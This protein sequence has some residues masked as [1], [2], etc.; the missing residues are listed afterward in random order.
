MFATRILPR[1]FIPPSSSL[2]RNQLVFLTATAPTVR[3]VGAQSASTSLTSHF[4]MTTRRS[5]RISA[6]TEA[7]PPAVGNAP[8]TQPPPAPATRP[9]KRKASLAW[10]TAPPT[11]PK[12]RAQ[13][14]TT[15]SLPLPSTPTATPSAVRLIAEPAATPKGSQTPTTP[16]P[17]SRA[18][19]RL[20]D[21]N[22]T[23]APLLSPET[24]RVVS[25]S[26][27]GDIPTQH[28]TTTANILEDACAH[29]IKGKRC[30]LTSI[31]CRPFC[32]GRQRY[33]PLRLRLIHHSPLIHSH[34]PWERLLC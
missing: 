1:I 16:K 11:T 8:P 25:K 13:N 28:P 10:E 22:S 21:P 7:T 12:R 29:L 26:L 23:N 30:S 33:D 14:S 3:L 20:A 24:S 15:V 31:E 17:K 18:V 19:A 5:A 2:F 6:L 34:S 32:P 9:S 27:G 4:T